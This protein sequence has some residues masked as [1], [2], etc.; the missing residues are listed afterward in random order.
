MRPP[1]TCA[2]SWLAT[3]STL[4]QPALARAAIGTLDDLEARWLLARANLQEGKPCEELPSPSR[5]PTARDPAPYVG[6]ASCIPC[7]QTIARRQRD[8]HHAR[9]FWARATLAK[10]PLPDHALADPANPAVVHT[11]RRVNEAVRVETRAEGRTYRA[12][13]AYAFGSGDRGLT[14]VGNDESGR[15][16]ELR[17]SRYADG[18]VWDV[19]PGHEAV[20]TGVLG[21]ARQEP[22][23]GRS[24]ALRRLPHDRPASRAGRRGA[25]GERPG[26]RL[27][28]V[29]RAGWQ[30]PQGRGRRPR[31]P[32]HR[33]AQTGPRR[34]DH[35]ALWSLPQPEGPHRLAFRPHLDP[36][37]VHHS[38]LEPML[39]AK[40]PP[41]RLRDVPRPSSRRRDVTGLLRVEV[42]QL[43]R[44]GGND[45][46]LG[47]SRARLHRMP[48]AHPQW[49]G[50]AF[51]IHR[52][53]YPGPCR[54]AMM[55]TPSWGDP[56][57]I[58]DLVAVIGDQ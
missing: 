6:A 50:P 13:L 14:P 7:H 35:A 11:I 39:H 23:R 38:H 57:G 27:R 54:I 55:P 41:A 26:N 21:L 8:S 49:R 40:R 52:S 4:G 24:E 45:P 16:C 22:E 37:P 20:P 46:L 34:A 1:R 44:H 3:G 58:D 12:V 2:S 18:P 30:P 28:A 5:D 48:H 33:P 47:Q 36:I 25:T 51:A 32:R 9:T 29:P 15:W 43:S 56:Q 53:S 17:M 19:T 31:R 10:I 42:P